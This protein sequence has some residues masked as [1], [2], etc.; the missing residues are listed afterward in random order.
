ME[1]EEEAE[2]AAKRPRHSAG[3][4]K[5]KA[6][7]KSKA[8]AAA[9]APADAGRPQQLTLPPLLELKKPAAGSVTPAPVANNDTTAAEVAVSVVPV[10]A[11]DEDEDE[12]AGCFDDAIVISTDAS[13]KVPLEG[14]EGKKEAL[15]PEG[16]PASVAAEPPAGDGSS[17]GSELGS[18]LDDPEE[19]DDPGFHGE[20]LV[21]GELFGEIAWTSRGKHGWSAQ[22]RN[23]FVRA[24]GVECLFSEASCKFDLVAEKLGGPR[25]LGTAGELLRQA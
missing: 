4:A 8:K 24:K 13:G 21:D 9:K 1:P 7:T 5:A 20:Q 6:K 11:L 23:G 12:Y 18:D 14:E 10:T 17:D 3:K 19:F 25:G 2:R 22:I 16:R 15:E